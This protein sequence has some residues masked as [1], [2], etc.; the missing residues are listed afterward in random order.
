MFK[1]MLLIQNPTID[2]ALRF[3]DLE[4]NGVLRRFQPNVTAC[5]GMAAQKDVLLELGPRSHVWHYCGHARFD[6][7]EPL[8]SALVLGS[9]EVAAFGEQWLTL[10]DVFTRLHLPQNSLSILNGCKTGMLRPEMADDYVNLSTGFLYAGARCVISTLWEVNDLSSALV[11]ER[12]YA[13]W[14]GDNGAKRLT[15]SAAL[16]EAVRWLREDIASGTQV[17]Q[18]LMPKLLAKMV[19]AD[20]RAHCEIASEE[21]AHLYPDR[22]PFASPMHWAPFVCSGAGHLLDSAHTELRPD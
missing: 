11:M 17:A 14:R 1:E 2:S 18:D 19:D 7:K 15:P 8:Q 21:L 4:G 9:S 16:R 13:L 10:R 22:P 12:F 3:T 5:R 6:A 20:A